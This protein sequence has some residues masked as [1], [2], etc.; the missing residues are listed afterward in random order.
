LLV[1]TP[2]GRVDISV[3]LATTLGFV[4]GGLTVAG[5]YALYP[6]AKGDVW[7]VPT[8]AVGSVLVV[9]LLYLTSARF[10]A[11]AGDWLVLGYAGV[12]VLAASVVVT[13]EVVGTL[14]AHV[15]ENL[16]VKTSAA[17][18]IEGQGRGMVRTGLPCAGSTP[19]SCAW[20]ARS[21][22]RL[23]PPWATRSA[24]SSPPRGWT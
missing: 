12:L 10:G 17:P 7:R 9:L 11:R 14:R 6:L 3:A 16:G 18:S 24:S 4:V 8:L 2:M 15:P 23:I 5:T 20:V 1:L 22:A 21:E 19:A 13:R